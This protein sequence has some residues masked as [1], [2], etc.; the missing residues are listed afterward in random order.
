M[1]TVAEIEEALKKLPVQKA[2]EIASWLQDH[3]DAQWGRQ[4]EQD[5]AAGKLDKVAEQAQAHYRAGRTK[6]LDEIIDHP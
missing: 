2:R 4:I 1:S 3:L 6:P 5:A